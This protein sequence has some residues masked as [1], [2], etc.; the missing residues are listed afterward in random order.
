M[1]PVYGEYADEVREH[2]KSPEWSTRLAVLQTGY[3]AT[4]AVTPER[5][6][7]ICAKCDPRTGGPWPDRPVSRPEV[8]GS[9]VLL[10]AATCPSR[11][12]GGC[13]AAGRLLADVDPLFA[14]TLSMPNLVHT[15]GHRLGSRP[16]RR[17]CCQ[18][19]PRSRHPV[20]PIQGDCPDLQDF[21]LVRVSHSRTRSCL[22]S[23]DIRLLPLDTEDDRDE[24]D[25]DYALAIRHQRSRSL[26][27][28]G[29]DRSMVI[30]AAFSNTTAS[31]PAVVR[32]KEPFHVLVRY[33]SPGLLLTGSV[34]GAVSDLVR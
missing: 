34:T 20:T 6:I 22:V 3:I 13:G 7:L 1:T 8:G 2:L 19:P 10:C 18:R 25:R 31:Q 33:Y 9:G 29:R 11:G 27:L 24:L 32:F 28:A 16:P 14:I 4:T 30:T 12:L 26:I 17:L 15:G 23:S 5:V 21:L